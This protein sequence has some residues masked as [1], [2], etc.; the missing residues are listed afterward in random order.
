MWDVEELI[1]KR[2]EINSGDLMYNMV[3]IIDIAALKSLNLLMG[4]I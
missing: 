4:E 1:T 2:N 3:I